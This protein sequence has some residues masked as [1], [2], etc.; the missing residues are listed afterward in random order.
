MPIERKKLLEKR[1]TKTSCKET[2]KRSIDCDLAPDEPG[3]LHDL[4]DKQN[5]LVGLKLAVRK[6]D[7]YGIWSSSTK[8]AL[9][10]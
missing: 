2:A 3:C 6:L 8:S 4:G 1:E 7:L 10:D 9:A 5:A